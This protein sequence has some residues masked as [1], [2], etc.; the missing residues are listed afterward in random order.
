MRKKG[1]KQFINISTVFATVATK[2]FIYVILMNSK[3][4]F[5]I[6]FIIQFCIRNGSKQR[7][8]FGHSCVQR[9]NMRVFT[10]SS[11]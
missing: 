1:E 4:Y 3:M 8:Y 6:A 2:L 9:W 5:E 7:I 11:V 10:I